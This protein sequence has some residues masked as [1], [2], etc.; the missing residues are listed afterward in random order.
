MIR[1]ILAL[2]LLA[3]PALAADPP[4]VPARNGMV[5]SAQRLASEAGLAML[6]QGGNAIDA[7]AAVG[8]ALAVTYPAAGN[9]GG[10]GFMLIR[11]ADGR[12]TFLDFREKAPGAA[13]AGMFLDDKGNVAPGRSTKSWLAV[14][15]PG[16]VA[17]LEAAR[18]KYGTLPR[19]AV[20]APAIRLARDGFV[21]TPGDMATL[22]QETDAFRRDPAAAAIFLPSGKPLQPGDRLVQ[23]DLAR[24]LQALSEQ[25]PDAFY[26]GPIGDAIVAASHAGGGILEKHDLELLQSPRAG[27]GRLHVS[28]L[29]GRL[30]AAALLGRDRHLRDPQHPRRLRPPQHGLPLGRRGARAGGGDAPR[31]RRPQ[32]AAR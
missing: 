12:S 25:G 4:P 23:P 19:A 1:R 18:A 32:L 10:G 5:V 15:V 7:A 21:L 13:T 8:Y 28:R 22:N 6:E 16:S 17:G 26:R 2:L 29:R 30:L 14:G 9:L 11:L 24:T 3:T 27:A 31:L 20:L